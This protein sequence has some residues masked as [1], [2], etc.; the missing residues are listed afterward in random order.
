MTE[1]LA[2]VAFENNASGARL[3]G[4]FIADTG[5]TWMMKP[6]GKPVQA[7]LKTEWTSVT[8]TRSRT[9]YQDI[10]DMFGGKQ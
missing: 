4:E 5:P 8:P 2:K 1:R 9:D 7:L 3:E 10:F 6:A